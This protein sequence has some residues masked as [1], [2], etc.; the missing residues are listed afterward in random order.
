LYINIVSDWLKISK[1][2]HTIVADL[3]QIDEEENVEDT[4]ELRDDKPEDKE[5]EALAI[6]DLD[7][8]GLEGGA[9]S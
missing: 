2:T 8:G 4:N 3:L 7:E 6:G 5:E 9:G 1:I